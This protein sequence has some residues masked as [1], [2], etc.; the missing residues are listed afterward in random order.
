MLRKFSFT[1][2]ARVQGMRN[3][4]RKEEIEVDGR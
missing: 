2:E 1:L 4:V 3:G